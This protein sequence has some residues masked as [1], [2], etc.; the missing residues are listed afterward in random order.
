MK[1]DQIAYYASN[2]KCEDY[3][4]DL[5]G[6]KNEPWIKDT[7][8]GMSSVWGKP[9]AENVGELQF[10]YSLGIEVEILRYV[11]GPNWHDEVQFAKEPF[12][13]HIGA[14]LEDGEDF[15]TTFLGRRV[16]QETFTKS[17]TSDYLTTGAGRGR[18]FHYKVFEINRGNYFKV[19]RRIRDNEVEY[20]AALKSK[21][22]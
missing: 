15:P 10:N 14:H 6:L 11:K 3:I 8:T 1:I 7:V 22:A 5:L 12:I 21:V 4:K 19:I 20:Q 18:L 16:A 17:H 2:Q 13:S 9:M